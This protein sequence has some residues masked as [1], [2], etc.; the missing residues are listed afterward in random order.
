MTTVWWGIYSRHSVG[1]VP[2]VVFICVVVLYTD[3][4]VKLLW[5]C[6]WCGRLCNTYHV[7]IISLHVFYLG[8]KSIWAQHVTLCPHME[9]VW[10]HL[11]FLVSDWCVSVL[12]PQEDTRSTGVSQ[13]WKWN[14]VTPEE[15]NNVSVLTWRRWMRQHMELEG[16][17]PAPS[18][19]GEA[20]HQLFT[21]WGVLCCGGSRYNFF[22]FSLSESS[23]IRWFLCFPESTS[24]LWGIHNPV[25]KNILLGSHST[26][27]PSSQRSLSQT[28]VTHNQWS[29][30]TP[31]TETSNTNMMMNVEM[32][33]ESVFE[34]RLFIDCY[35]L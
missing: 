19:L 20:S 25:I 3:T 16:C 6:I 9:T 7:K 10:N 35:N 11:L 8:L 31:S 23:S 32:T 27:F 4:G 34:Q 2:L 29:C 1:I 5:S 15:G 13:I 28:G 24:L 18:C 12:L 17:F 26:S 14:K 33:A 22:F 21:L 30:I